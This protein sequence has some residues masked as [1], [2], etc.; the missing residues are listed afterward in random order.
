[1][2]LIIQSTT[3]QKV[4][5]TTQTRLIQHILIL[6]PKEEKSSRG[7]GARQGVDWH[8]VDARL[9]SCHEKRNTIEA[10]KI[11][12][13]NRNKSKGLCNQQKAWL[14]QEACWQGNNEIRRYEEKGERSK[15]P[16]L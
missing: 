6:I 14:E 7:S 1:M 12:D 11:V 15:K 9:S 4:S 8:G 13:E 3:S 16:C 5:K 10:R 2:F